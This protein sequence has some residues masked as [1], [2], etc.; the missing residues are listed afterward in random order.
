MSFQPADEK[1]R[2]EDARERPGQKGVTQPHKADLGQVDG[3]YKKTDVN[4]AWRHSDHQSQPKEG[5]GSTDC[6][7]GHEPHCRWVGRY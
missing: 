2:G 7:G 1:M 5:Q 6:S 4:S 3:G